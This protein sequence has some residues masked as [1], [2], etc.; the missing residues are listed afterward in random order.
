[1]HAL[2]DYRMAVTNGCCEDEIAD[3]RHSLLSELKL[4]EHWT[5][6]QA[7]LNSI[8]GSDDVPMRPSRRSGKL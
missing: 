6:Y 2:T 3:A 5:T 8:C 7:T 1:M 4:S